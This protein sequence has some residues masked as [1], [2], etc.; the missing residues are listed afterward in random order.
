M[1]AERERQFA[2]VVQVVLDDMPEHPLTRIPGFITAVVFPWIP[3][4]KLFRKIGGRPATQGILDHRTSGL[5]SSGQ[6]GGAAPRLPRPP[7]PPP[8]RPGG[9]APPPPE[10]DPPHAP[11]HDM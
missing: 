2:A 3:V 6:F 5:Q 11:G 4:L 9:G 8:R 10:T 7:P 1:H